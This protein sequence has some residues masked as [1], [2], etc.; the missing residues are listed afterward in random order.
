MRFSVAAATLLYTSTCIQG[1]LTYI[2][3]NKRLLQN[4]GA[5]IQFAKRKGMKPETDEIDLTGGRP[6]AVIESE[7]EL[8]RKEVIFEELN[9]GT[10]EA[11]DWIAEYQ[12]DVMGEGAMFDS[13]D[14]DALDSSTLGTYTILDLKSKFD[15]ELDPEK[16]DPDP[17]NQDPGFSYLDENPK[18]EDG[19]EIGY[20]PIFGSPNPIDTR[21][22]VGTVDSFMIDE[23]TKDE[24][25]L[26]PEFH[27]GD[28]E[29][30]FNEDVRT[31]RKSLDIIESFTDPFLGPEWE[32]PRNVA[33]W[34]G[35]PQ[36][37]SYPEKNFTNNRFTKDEDLTPFDDYSPDRARKTAVQ[38]ARAQNAEWL[39]EGVSAAFHAA[40]R[41]PYEKVGTLIGTLREGVSDPAIVEQILPALKVLGGSVDLLSI[42]GKGTIFRFVYH[43][44]MKNKFGM[45]CWAQTLIRDCG[46]EVDNVVF[47]TGFRKRDPWYDGGDPWY[48]PH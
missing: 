20:N 5:G 25:L 17:N 45:S 35:L 3:Q 10:R 39:P 38:Y 11:P 8:E 27:P 44:L 22:I 12:G 42:E 13:D 33:K 14:P 40:E 30:G 32:V 36:R 24:A 46:V 18:D 31:F 6:G 7:E 15:Y 34:H 48:G 4:A 37:L 21:T 43:G 23:Q 1:F 16:G 29:E 19:I 28:V 9:D 2:P 26:T 41:A 47:E